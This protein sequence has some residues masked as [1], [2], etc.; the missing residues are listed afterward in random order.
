MRPRL[1]SQRRF[2]VEPDEAAGYIRFPPELT[3]VASPAPHA[4]GA[5]NAEKN[6]GDVGFVFPWNIDQP[7]VGRMDDCMRVDDSLIASRAIESPFGAGEKGKV[8]ERKYS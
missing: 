3:V 6:V 1:V 5:A 8:T 7:M 4:G 2:V